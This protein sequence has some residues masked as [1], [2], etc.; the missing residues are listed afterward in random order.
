MDK[1]KISV[2]YLQRYIASKKGQLDN[3]DPQTMYIKL[4]EEVGELARHMI[5]GEKHAT[6]ADDLKNSIEEELYDI[7]YY[8]LMLANKE[9][10]DMETWIPLKE[11][12]NNKR[13]PSGV[14]FDPEDDSV[15]GE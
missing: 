13:Y 15:Y 11:D 9:N 3:Y 8:T 7:L 5:R 12:M 10:V 14:T 4:S 1:G 6:G 2:R